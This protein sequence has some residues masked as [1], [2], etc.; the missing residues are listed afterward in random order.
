[1]VSERALGDRTTS[2]VTPLRRHR[3]ITFWTV[4]RRCNYSLQVSSRSAMTSITRSLQ[5]Y[6]Q[7]GFTTNISACLELQGPIGP[8]NIK[9]AIRALQSE[10]PF[11]RMGIQF[12][13]AG[14]MT[15]SELK[16]LD[17]QL[18]T[19][20]RCYQSWQSKLLNFANELRDWSESVLYTELASTAGSNDHQ[21]FL[22]VNHAGTRTLLRGLL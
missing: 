12:T 1:M 4:A 18:V 19:G 6:E 2:A 10:H 20:A 9:S 16:H 22:T 17:V 8:E 13:D 7:I 11:L 5:K 15:F 14:V 3:F 21:L